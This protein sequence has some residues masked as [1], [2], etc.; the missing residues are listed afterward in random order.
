MQLLVRTTFDA[1]FMHNKRQTSYRNVC[2]P[3][4]WLHY[5]FLDHHA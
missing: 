3:R 4:R 1:V 5:R 2:L